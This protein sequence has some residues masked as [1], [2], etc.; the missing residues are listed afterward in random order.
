MLVCVAWGSTFL[1][2]KTAVHSIPPLLLVG[3]RCLSAGTLLWLLSRV[4]GVGYRPRWGLAFIAGSLL[5][6]GGH[7][8]LASGIRTV[9]SGVAAVIQATIPLWVLVLAYLVDRDA[10]PG[11][12]QMAGVVV[13]LV[14]VA[15]L[16][17][18][19]EV[20]GEAMDPVGTGLLFAGALGWSAGTVLIRHSE[21]ARAP[22]RG[23]AMQLLAGGV[24]VLCA[25]LLVGDPAR[26]DA[27]TFSVSSVGALAYLVIVGSL[28]AFLAYNWL[29]SEIP[30]TRVASYAYVMPVIAVFL[31]WGLAG[32]EL[33]PRIIL[34]TVITIVGVALVVTPGRQPE[35]RPDE[36]IPAGG[37]ASERQRR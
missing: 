5:F 24:V 2:W 19:W 21:L 25:S 13:G 3:L 16:S 26:V 34:S 17:A 18:P 15:L 32:E 36:S 1:A 35:A 14:G 30:S 7:G 4:V 10:R 9:P 27:A 12:L 6:L 23:T 20:G 11:G 8:A 22:L 28:L 31:G 33:T 29:L 37:A